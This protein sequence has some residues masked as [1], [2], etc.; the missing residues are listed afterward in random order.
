MIYYD[1]SEFWQII[2]HWRGGFVSRYVLFR[3]ALATVS[4]S[5]R[6]VTRRDQKF[7]FEREGIREKS[8]SVSLCSIFMAKDVFFDNKC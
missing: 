5:E 2:F 1:T 3:A 6:V 4:G 8:H 7:C